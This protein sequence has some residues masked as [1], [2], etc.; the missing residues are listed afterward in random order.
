MHR[1]PEQT[2]LFSPV[3]PSDLDFEGLSGTFQ[4]LFVLFYNGLDNG[5]QTTVDYYATPCS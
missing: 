4:T 5:C 2:Q 3:L 1:L